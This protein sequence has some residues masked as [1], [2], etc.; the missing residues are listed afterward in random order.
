MGLPV[1]RLERTFVQT[2][3][4]VCERVIALRSRQKALAGTALP[5]DPDRII[6]KPKLLA[7]RNRAAI[8]DGR[9]SSNPKHRFCKS[10]KYRV[11]IFFLSKIAPKLVF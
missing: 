10:H 11:I 5:D 7:A 9:A 3:G 4:D 8:E 1:G 2:F 6:D